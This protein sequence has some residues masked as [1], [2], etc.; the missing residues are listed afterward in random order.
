MIT[1]IIS[2][3]ALL[4]TTLPINNLP[5]M[6]GL[7]LIAT[8]KHNNPHLAAIMLT[9]QGTEDLATYSLHSGAQDYIPKASL[10]EKRLYLSVVNA[11]EKVTLAQQIQQQ[12]KELEKAKDLAENQRQKAV[13]ADHAKSDF[14]A[15]MSHEI[16]TPMNGIIGM[17]ELLHYTKLSNKQ[18]QYVDS[19]RSSGDLLLTIINDILD[20]SKIEAQEL[21]LDV[22]SVNLE[23]TLKNVL[24]LM[25][26]RAIDHRVELALKWPHDFEIPHIKAD[27]TRIRQI[28]INLIGNAIKFTKDGY[29]LVSTVVTKRTKHKISLR[30]EVEDSGIGIAK[31]KIEHIFTKFTQADSSTTRKFGGT[32]LGL[33]ICS[34]LV[35]LMGGKIGANSVEGVGSTFWFEVTFPIDNPNQKINQ[36]PSYD[37]TGQSILIVDD[38]K[39]NIDLFSEYLNDTGAEIMGAHCGQ[40]ALQLLQEANQ[41]GKPF[42]IVFID[43]IMPQMNGDD[44]AKK[45]NKNS[46]AYGSP[47]KILFT[48]MG[49]RNAHRISKKI[50]FLETL[51]KPIYP[52]ELKDAVAR[53][54]QDTQ[55]PFEGFKNK[56]QDLTVLPRV[57]ADILIVDDDRISQRMIKSVLKE[58]KCTYDT[59]DNGKEALEILHDNHKQYDLVFMDWQMPIMDGHQAI[60]NIRKTSWGEAIKITALTANVIQ[61]DKEKC[62]AAGANEYLSK[63]VRIKDV[64]QMMETLGVY[65]T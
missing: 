28:L 26:S 18:K 65:K 9:G 42:D 57:N 10:S 41:N 63:P 60:Q 44:L 19:I 40:K 2:F 43:Y 32:G 29:V 39:L 23:D 8:L 54:V 49:N 58:L 15:T 4:M 64:V 55:L 37:F 7:S 61:G 5:D 25:S 46:E 56:N 50:G 52:Y 13:H 6:D 34:R 51:L 17:A 35:S 30:F 20:F 53:A 24:Q 12:N 27:A 11:I 33:T 36:A 16:R 14:L 1:A 31:D 45:I 38:H 21:E 47:K 62:L 48:A 22:H 59:A 3:K